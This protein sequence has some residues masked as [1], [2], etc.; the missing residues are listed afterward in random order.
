MNL[1]VN[2]NPLKRIF[3]SALNNDPFEQIFWDN[4]TAKTYTNAINN[5][6]SMTV[7]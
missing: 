4:P 2:F 6:N 7:E 3:K 1:N 5:Y